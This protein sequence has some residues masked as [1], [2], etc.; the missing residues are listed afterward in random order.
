MVSE[1][2]PLRDPVREVH[3][4]RDPYREP[5]REMREPIDVKDLDDPGFELQRRCATFNCGILRKLRLG[6]GSRNRYRYR[7]ASHRKIYGGRTRQLRER[8][9]DQ[10]KVCGLSFRSVKILNF[11]LLIIYIFNNT[12]NT[13]TKEVV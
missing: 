7:Y 4:E 5:D 6:L 12:N 3:R 13:E 10:I 8:N 2:I 11:N 9:F 1:S